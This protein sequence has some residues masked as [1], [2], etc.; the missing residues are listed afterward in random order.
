[1]GDLKDATAS[2]ETIESMIDVSECC[3]VNFGAGDHKRGVLNGFGAP[4]DA[5][6]RLL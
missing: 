2:R 3:E 5:F 1:M 6:D 4:W